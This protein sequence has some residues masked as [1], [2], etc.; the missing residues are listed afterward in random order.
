MRN[1]RENAGKRAALWRRSER[2]KG[3]KTLVFAP[4]NK[5]KNAGSKKFSPIEKAVLL[6]TPKGK[7]APR[8]PDLL[9]KVIDIA[10]VSRYNMRMIK[11]GDAYCGN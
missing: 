5:R 6:G 8:A 4:K 10:R 7:G 2:K 3:G 11:N 1:K 9:G